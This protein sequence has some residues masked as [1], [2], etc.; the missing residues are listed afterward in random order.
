MKH[1]DKKITEKSLRDTIPIN[2]MVTGRSEMN[3][4]VDNSPTKLGSICS[5]ICN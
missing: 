1:S 4:T 2:R 5:S 3:E